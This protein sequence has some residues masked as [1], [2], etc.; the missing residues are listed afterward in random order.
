M[1]SMTPHPT[2][3][4]TQSGGVDAPWNLIVIKDAQAAAAFKHHFEA[5]FGGGVALPSREKR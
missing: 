3:A 1:Q 2:K 4:K 5:R